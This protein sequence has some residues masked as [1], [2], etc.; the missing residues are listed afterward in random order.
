MTVSGPTPQ[1][2]LRAAYKFDWDTGQA[3]RFVPFNHNP[4]VCFPS[5][6]CELVADLGVSPV[7]IGGTTLPFR[8]YLFRRGGEDFHVFY[9]IWDNGRNQPL[10][11]EDPTQGSLVWLR[12]AWDEVRLRRLNINAKMFIYAMFGAGDGPATISA[13]QAEVRHVLAS[14][15]P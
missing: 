5:A 14:R 15:T 11:A 7:R 9:L 1:G 6:G 12:Q 4:A 2:G 3:A 8:S 10:R 13:F